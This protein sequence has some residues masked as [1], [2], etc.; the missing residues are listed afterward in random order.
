MLAN[1]RLINGVRL[2]VTHLNK[3]IITATFIYSDKTVTVPRIN[4]TPSDPSMAFQI[5]W[6][7]FPI[8]VTFSMTI[9]SAQTHER[10]YCI[11]HNMF[12]AWIF[13]CRCVTIYN[14]H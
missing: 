2:L 10:Q 13:K 6:K 4:F 9:N 1:K 11:Y 8:T 3:N 5:I 14:I 12:F 7:Q